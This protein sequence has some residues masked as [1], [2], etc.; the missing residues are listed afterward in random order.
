MGRR[1]PSRRLSIFLIKDNLH[2]PAEI[3]DRPHELRRKEVVSGS[4]TIGE[5]FLRPSR[6]HPPRWASF[7][8]GQIDLGMLISA[9]SA[10]VFLVPVRD[11]KIALTFGY[12]RHLLVPGS[13]E[14]N[15]GLLVTLNSVDPHSIRIIDRSS[16][17]AIGRRTREQSS[18]QASISAFGL[19]VE[20]DILRAV[21]G[22]PTDATFA[23]S[24]SGA[25][26]LLLSAHAEL[27][28]LPALLEKC[29]TTYHEEAYKEKYPWIGQ[30]SEIRDQS[31][32]RRLEAQLVGNLQRKDLKQIWLAVPEIL[33][34]A[35]FA[36]FRYSTAPRGGLHEDVHLSDF[37]ETLRGPEDLS[38]ERL[39]R[40][41]VVAID[42]ESEEPGERWPVYQCIYAEIEH[43]G[44]L[45]VLDSA[46]WYRI[47]SDFV[48]EITE[49]ISQIP[50][51]ATDLPHFQDTSEAAYNRRVSQ[52]L[53]E[54]FKLLDGKL[55]IRTG[56][57]GPI[58]FCDLLSSKQQILHVKRY[59]KSSG[60]SHL[61][62]QAT[63]SAE[64]FLRD[65]GFREEVNKILPPSHRLTDPKQRPNPETYEIVFCIISRSDKELVLPFFSRVNLRAAVRRLQDWGYRVSLKKIPNRSP[66]TNEG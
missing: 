57:R 40:T 18:K 8:G 61:F 1:G 50:E 30:M 13:W 49:E 22:R 41:K 20:Q 65:P 64:L 3:I 4:K 46:K 15:F 14:E 7:F 26:S 2:S 45:Y 11:R 56:A 39:K 23:S 19:D 25:D 51:F 33:D 27:S 6:Q 36:G 34:W 32:I 52:T 66:A 53:P 62:S 16:L 9:S 59:C 21:S 54:A 37:I 63:V 60:L 42:A 35:R 28:D 43:G 17:D 12:G 31:L 48:A 44:N 38:I 5:L 29:L 10:A 55:V 58:E 24:L 47:R